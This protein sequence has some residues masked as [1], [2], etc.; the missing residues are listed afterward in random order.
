MICA[1]LIYRGR[2]KHELLHNSSKKS[3]S[4]QPMLTPFTSYFFERTVSL[5]MLLISSP[6][7]SHLYYSLLN[8]CVLIIIYINRNI[9][10]TDRTSTGNIAFIQASQTHVVRKQSTKIFVI[11]RST[12]AQ[13]LWNH[14]FIVSDGKDNAMMFPFF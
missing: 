6:D 14:S 3:I 1:L 12:M 11:P 9:A 13:A 7:I 4:L 8:G 5:L 2:H 10:I